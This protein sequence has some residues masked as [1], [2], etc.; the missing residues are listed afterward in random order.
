M[1][2]N[3]KITVHLSGDDWASATLLATEAELDFLDRLIKELRKPENRSGKYVPRFYYSDET[4]AEMQ[5]NERKKFEVETRQKQ[6]R[7]HLEAEEAARKAELLANGPF[8]RAFREA[9]ERQRQKEV[10]A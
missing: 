3:H 9:R 10:S 7:A 4:V 8:A 5:K 1:A 2:E 6:E